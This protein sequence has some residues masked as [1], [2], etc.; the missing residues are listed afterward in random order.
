[1]FLLLSCKFVFKNSVFLDILILSDGQTDSSIIDELE[2]E[3]EIYFEIHYIY[4]KRVKF[5]QMCSV[6]I[7]IF[8]IFDSRLQIFEISI[9]FTRLI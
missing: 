1:M 6:I 2:N 8:G 3:K 7:F 4:K 9:T 5:S